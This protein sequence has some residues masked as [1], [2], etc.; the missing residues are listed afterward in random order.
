VRVAKSSGRTVRRSIVAP[1]PWFNWSATGDLYT[2]MPRRSSAGNWSKLTPRLSLVE[3]CSRPFKV[4]VEKSGARPRTLIVAARPVCL[5]RCVERPGRREMVSATLM[6]GNLPISS[7]EID[8]TIES[9]FFLMLMAL[10]MPLRMPV[11]VTVCVT[12]ASCACATPLLS[13]MATAAAT[14]VACKNARGTLRRV[15]EWVIGCLLKLVWG[16]VLGLLPAGRQRRSGVGIGDCGWHC[17]PKLDSSAPFG[18]PRSALYRAPR[19]GGLDLAPG[20]YFIGR[21]QALPRVG[22]APPKWGVNL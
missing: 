5:S 3:A 22:V 19:W 2:S 1:R 11:T 18:N 17:V 13:S 6:S 15:R 8:S 20:R 14:G 10:S 9:A 12:G 21:L 7:A 4:P 16:G